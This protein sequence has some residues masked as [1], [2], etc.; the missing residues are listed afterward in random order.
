[1]LLNKDLQQLTS[2]GLSQNQIRQQL[3]LFE[4]GFPH[5]QLQKAATI[6]NGI[7]SL[8]EEEAEDFI[9]TY[10]NDF[11]GKVE[12]FVPASGAASRMFKQV[13]AWLD[14]RDHQD[15][16][17]RIIT[18]LKKFAFYPQLKKVLDNKGLQLDELL[19]TQDYAPIFTTLLEDMNYGNLPKGLLSF[20][21]YE[22][23]ETRLAIEEQLLES[24]S[25][26]LDKDDYIRIHFTIA[27]Q[28]ILT[29]K[30]AI[31]KLRAKYAEELG[32]K[33]VLSY[34]VQQP[35]TD[36]IAVDEDNKPFRNHIGQITFRPGGH[37]ALLSNLNKLNADLIFIKNIDNVQHQEW[38]KS[39][40]NSKKTLA[41]VLVH[42]QNLIFE[43]LQKIEQHQLTEEKL[44][45]VEQKINQFYNLPTSY[46]STS[47]EE[48]KKYLYKIL[49]RPIRVCGMVKNEGQPGGGP[50]WVKHKDGSSSLQIVEMAQIDESNPTNKS[51]IAE[52][53]HFNPVD[54]VCS[55]KDHK[56]QK[57]NLEEFR[58]PETGFI[59]IKSQKGKTLK[60]L[61]HPGLWNGSMEGW[62]TIFVEVPKQT[63]SPVKCISDLLNE[64][65]LP[66][67]NPILS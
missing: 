8:T 62:N 10:E 45:D 32:K 64:A 11:F 18:N 13:F 12:K 39:V 66:I 37:G 1:M 35:G 30:D 42:Y 23:E 54:I 9:S 52:A 47:F 19:E 20:H 34:S 55:I 3:L 14:C 21:N 29:F 59:S 7:L 33:L 4:K 65:H 60:A 67:G 41:G 25:Y 56:G 50:F 26:M 40:S 38:R 36:T 22:E 43:T 24:V 61:E 28:H 63:F 15:T 44:K 51:L 16:I 46:H 5:L 58:N 2:K 27:S 17:D 31:K 6:K 57:F 49:N 53:T 48:K